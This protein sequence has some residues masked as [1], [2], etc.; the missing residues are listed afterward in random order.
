MA[1]YEATNGD[2]WKNNEGWLSEG[3]LGGWWGVAVEDGC[4]VGLDLRHN[5]L[6]GEIPRALANL[7]KLA[8][9]RMAFNELSGSIPG[10]LGNIEDLVSLSLAPSDLRR[11]SK[12][13]GLGAP[14][15]M[16]RAVELLEAILARI[17]EIEKPHPVSERVA[18]LIRDRVQTLL[19]RFGSRVRE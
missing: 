2:E 18:A 4:V 9:I 15:V 13:A 16:R 5:G 1:L 6:A 7:T 3:S 17:D 10:E 19:G 8:S 14:L 12:E 11:L